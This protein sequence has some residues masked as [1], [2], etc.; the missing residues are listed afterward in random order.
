MLK[1]EN[2]VLHGRMSK[3]DSFLKTIA[4]PREDTASPTS[5]ENCA[6]ANIEDYAQ[7]A[8]PAMAAPTTFGLPKRM[9]ASQPYFGKPSRSSLQIPRA[10]MRSD[11]ENRAESSNFGVTPSTS[12]GSARRV[13]FFGTGPPSTDNRFQSS[14]PA[15]AGSRLKRPTQY[16]KS[17]G[18]RI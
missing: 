3:A 13:S 5:I 17:L 14:I 12:L 7:P 2:Q 10:T 1:A 9:R 8:P 11:Q 4:E 16:R 15:P 6:R 18:G